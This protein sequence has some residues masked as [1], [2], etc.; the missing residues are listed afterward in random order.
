[1]A[2]TNNRAWLSTSIVDLMRIEADDLNSGEILDDENCYCGDSWPAPPAKTMLGPVPRMISFA[3]LAY[4]LS[5]NLH[6]LASLSGVELGP[7][8]V[9][10]STL[11]DLSHYDDDAADSMSFCLDG[12]TYTAFDDAPSYVFAP[13]R[14]MS[15]LVV[16]DG[17][18][19]SSQFEPVALSPCFCGTP[20]HWFE[21]DDEPRFSPREPQAAAARVFELCLPG[22]NNIALAIGTRS[23]DWDPCFVHFYVSEV[24]DRA[25]SLGLALAEQLDATLPP[26]VPTSIGPA[27]RRL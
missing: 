21:G 4:Q 10:L 9:V 2:N 18:H 23:D 14:E 19:C 20:G 11:P 7:A 3:Q 17:N 13:G 12:K 24:I 22:S 15:F 5:Q 8:G 26:A 16:R 1:M 6:E 27:K 25:R